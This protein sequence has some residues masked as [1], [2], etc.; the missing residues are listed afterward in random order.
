M[1]ISG[2]DREGQVGCILHNLRLLAV[3][4]AAG[5]LVTSIFQGR[6]WLG[7]G[8]S[9]SIIAIYLGVGVLLKRMIKK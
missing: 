4:L 8:A 1:K 6:V 9:A 7:I 5:V 2:E 3:L